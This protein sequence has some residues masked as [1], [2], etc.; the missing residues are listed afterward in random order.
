MYAVRGGYLAVARAVAGSHVLGVV[1]AS[2]VYAPMRGMARASLDVPRDR[3]GDT[4]GREVL[5]TWD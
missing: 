3:P 4:L 5:G 2:T 1:A